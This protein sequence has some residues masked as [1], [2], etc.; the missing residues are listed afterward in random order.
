MNNILGLVFST[1][2]L[3]FKSYGL[4]KS[5]VGTFQDP[6]P[7][8]DKIPFYAS[9]TSTTCLIPY[10]FMAMALGNFISNFSPVHKFYTVM[11][12]STIVNMIRNPLTG[13]HYFS[14]SSKI[15]CTYV[16]QKYIRPNNC[17]SPFNFCFPLSILGLEYV[18]SWPNLAL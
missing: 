9:I 8:I 1:S 5:R 11:V 12:L 2:I 15:L 14:Y 17:I 3:D 10:I 13:L 4:A 6:V 18:D 7:K 16:P